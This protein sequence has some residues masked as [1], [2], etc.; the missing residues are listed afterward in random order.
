V[1]VAGGCTRLGFDLPAEAD[2]YQAADGQ[3]VD[4][5]DAPDA[6]GRRDG[7]IPDAAGRDTRPDGGSP[8]ARDPFGQGSWQLGPVQPLTEINLSSWDGEPCLSGDRLTLYFSSGRPGGLGNTDIYAARRTGPSGPFTTID[9]LTALNTAGSEGFVESPDGLLAVLAGTH[10]GSGPGAADMWIGQRTTTDTAWQASLF[11][12]MSTINSVRS[13]LDP[14]LG[15][16]GLRL[17]YAPSLPTG[18]LGG[19]DL[20]VAERAAPDAS[21]TGPRLLPELNSADSEADPALSPDQRVIVF[22]SL[23]PGGAGGADLWFATRSTSSQTFSAPQPLAAVNSAADDGEA[24]ISYDGTELYF[25]SRRPGGAGN[26]DLYR[27]AILAGP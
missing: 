20:V 18:G 19:Q 6:P 25:A 16:D 8:D 12:L 14:L 4:A 21:F 7:R 5:A 24:F 22:T 10:D 13:D 3:I 15:A 2:P 17:Y 27:A 9:A 26:Y 11:Q 1:L 23:R